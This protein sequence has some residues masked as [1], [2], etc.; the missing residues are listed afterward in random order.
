MLPRVWRIILDVGQ[1][2]TAKVQIFFGITAGLHRKTLLF[3]IV[4]GINAR[5]RHSDCGVMASVRRYLVLYGQPYTHIQKPPA[6]G[7]CVPYPAS[8]RQRIQESRQPG[9]ISQPHP[10]IRR[11]AGGGVFVWSTHARTYNNLH[12]KKMA[13]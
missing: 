9:I 1:T 4:P 7:V 13:V 12:T 10:G 2:H 6:N 5:S 3:L 8:C 11:N